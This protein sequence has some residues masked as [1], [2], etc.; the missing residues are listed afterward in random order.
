M[1]ITIRRAVGFKEMEEMTIA[2]P[3]LFKRYQCKTEEHVPI[4][5]DSQLWLEKTISR[6]PQFAVDDDGKEYYLELGTCVNCGS[7]LAFNEPV[8]VEVVEASR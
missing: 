7:T 2:D 8:P 6:G 4:T 5:N 3:T 1:T